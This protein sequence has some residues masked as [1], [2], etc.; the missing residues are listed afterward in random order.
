MRNAKVCRLGGASLA[1]NVLPPCPIRRLMQIREEAHRQGASEEALGRLWQRL[2]CCRQ[3][4]MGE[5]VALLGMVGGGEPHHYDPAPFPLESTLASRTDGTR[6]K[7]PS[8]AAF[9]P[10]CTHFRC[11]A[12]STA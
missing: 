2:A 12:F 5:G 1:V 11:H 8:L 4:N 9:K 6:E 3:G 7:N 10:R